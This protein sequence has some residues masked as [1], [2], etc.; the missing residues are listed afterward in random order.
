MEA[1]GGF[2]AETR[3]TLKRITMPAVLRGD[4]KG[5]GQREGD[6]GRRKNSWKATTIMQVKDDSGSELGG[7][8]AD[9][10]AWSESGYVVKVEQKGFANGL[11][12]G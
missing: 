9:G 7:S 5:M 2:G 10:E 12:M 4:G 8:A 3:L 1:I 6:K 11:D